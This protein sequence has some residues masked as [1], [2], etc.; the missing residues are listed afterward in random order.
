[1]VTFVFWRADEEAKSVCVL[2]LGNRQSFEA[3]K[4]VITQPRYNDI[5]LLRRL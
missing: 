4:H 1:M 3:T 2:K 5:A